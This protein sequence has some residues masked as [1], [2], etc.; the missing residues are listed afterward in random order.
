MWIKR[1]RLLSDDRNNKKQKNDK[2]IVQC[3]VYPKRENQQIII[4][5]IC[6]V[7]LWLTCRFEC[8]SKNFTL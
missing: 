5:L 4:I 1:G 8:G 6:M 2:E 3:P 7:L